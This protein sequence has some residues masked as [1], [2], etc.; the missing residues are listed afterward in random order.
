MLVVVLALVPMVPLRAAQVAA[1]IAVILED[2]VLRI[3]AAGALADQT[4][5]VDVL[6]EL[7]VQVLLL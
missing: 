3:E 1:V 5:L 2:Q 7:E 6:E 4:V